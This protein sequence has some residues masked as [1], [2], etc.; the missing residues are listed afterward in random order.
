MKRRRVLKTLIASAVAFFVAPFAYAIGK[1]LSFT[2][3][4]LNGAS[5]R[6]AQS[7]VSATGA[8]QILDISGEPVIVVHE[9]SGIR[10]FTATC[11][12]MGCVVRYR[13]DHNDFYCRCHQGRFDADGVNV[14][15]TKPPSPL[16]ELIVREKGSDV[17]VV[18][19]PK[20]RSAT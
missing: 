3:S 13:S 14:P 9:P 5:A 7:D 6:V 20:K 18:L 2:G 16:T 10:A 4:V 15:G 12:H 19:T 17:E 8:S 11:T 1:Y